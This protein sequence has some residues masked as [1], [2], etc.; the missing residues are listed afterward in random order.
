MILI[1]NN[2]NSD[3]YIIRIWY[4]NTNT[5]KFILQGHTSNVFGLKQISSDIFA[6][7][8]YHTAIKLW[9]ITSGSLIRSLTGHTGNIRLSVDVLNSGYSQRLVSGSWDQTIKIW[10]YTTGDCLNTIQTGANIY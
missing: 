3:D 2:G 7:G 6:S 4:L 5:I 8:S 10:N 1:N 9:N